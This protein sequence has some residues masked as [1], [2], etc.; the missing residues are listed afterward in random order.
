MSV[1]VNLRRRAMNGG[2]TGRLRELSAIQPAGAANHV[3]FT[4]SNT[5]VHGHHIARHRRRTQ[6][7]RV[8]VKSTAI[9]A[10]GLLTVM[11]HKPR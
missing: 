1:P 6:R 11:A 9:P 4:I 10:L 8:T 5:L 7:I 2:M 3:R